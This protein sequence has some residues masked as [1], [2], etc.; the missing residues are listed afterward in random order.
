MNKEEIGVIGIVVSVLIWIVS[1]I[2]AI[3]GN[4]WVGLLVWLFSL[5]MFIKSRDIRKESQKEE[6][7]KA[8]VRFGAEHMDN[9][10]GSQFESLLVSVFSVLG[11]NVS[12]TPATG[13][14]G[15][16]LLMTM[17]DKKIAV[18][19]K[20]RSNNVGNRA[21]QEVCAGMLHYGADEGWVVTNS[22]FTKGAFEQAKSAGITLVDRKIL[23]KYIILAN[24]MI[25]CENE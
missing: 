16:D 7:I 11:Y 20:R 8:L 12:I 17:D 5:V 23:M 21:V 18:Q 22:G 19:A 10:T 4:F 2:I 24:E 6:A 14:Y 9:M 3:S 25:E 13:D 1:I 15:A